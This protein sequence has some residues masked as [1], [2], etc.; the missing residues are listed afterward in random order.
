MH[1]FSQRVSHALAGLA[2]TLAFS[3]AAHANLIG[4]TLTH[5]CPECGP[6]YSQQFVVLEGAPELSPF[7]Q[8]TLD[9]EAS[10]IR[11]TWLI[12]NP[13]ISP[14]HLIVD[15]ILGGIDSVSVDANSTLLP[16]GL[17]FTQ[18]SVTLDL[19]G[20]FEAVAG[21]FTLVNV[22]QVP[23]PGSL[24]LLGI[25]LVGLHRLRRKRVPS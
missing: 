25:G 4:Q 20:A 1:A 16:T 11:I 22:N 3:T 12:T 8:W 5:Q 9:V 6:P 17:S 24:A 7:G 23:E 19:G 18:D 13:L 14:L 21:G 2:A 15:D 10:T